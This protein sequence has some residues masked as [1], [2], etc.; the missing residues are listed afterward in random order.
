MFIFSKYSNMQVLALLV[1]FFPLYLFSQDIDEILFPKINYKVLEFSNS[2][3]LK[4]FLQDFYPKKDFIR[5]RVLTTLNRK[6]LRFFRPKQKIIVPDTFIEDLRAYSVFPYYYDGAKEVPKLIVV[7]NVYQAYA[8]YEYGK[9]VRF[10]GVNT[11][12]STTPTYPGR[13]SLYWRDRLRRSSFNEEWIMPFTWNFHLLIGAAFHQFEMPGYPAS[14]SCIRQFK[15]DAEWLY[16]WGDPAKRNKNGYVKFSGTPVIIIDFY[17][18][19][20]RRKLW[21]ELVSNEFKIDYLPPN[22]MEV[23]EALIPIQ[24]VPPDLRHLLSKEEYKRYLYAEDTLKARG[25]LPKNI[26]LTP[27][28]PLQKKDSISTTNK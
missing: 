3:E 17:D 10:V 9:L 2:T 23:E 8:C 25:I 12:K 15:E 19:V 21:L 13:Y 4:K 5:Y 6:E 11:G 7:S 1:C 28:K 14:H 24:H 16:H 26:R 22:P 18:F 20:T 27:S